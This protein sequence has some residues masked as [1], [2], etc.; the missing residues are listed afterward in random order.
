MVVQYFIGYDFLCG[1]FLFRSSSI[2]FKAQFTHSGVVVLGGVYTL[3]PFFEQ[4]NAQCYASGSMAPLHVQINV[5]TTSGNRVTR[6][7]STCCCA[8]TAVHH[9]H[10]GKIRLFEGNVW[11]SWRR[12]LVH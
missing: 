6:L 7:A 3:S 4:C 8:G 9:I 1:F 11:C 5:H 10:C 2:M 12:Q